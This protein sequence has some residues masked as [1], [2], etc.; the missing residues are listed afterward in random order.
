MKFGIFIHWG[1]FSVPSYGSEWFWHN[2]ACGDTKVKQFADRNFPKVKDD[3][4][5]YANL[6]KAELFDADQWFVSEWINGPTGYLMRA[7][8]S[9]S[10]Q[11]AYTVHTQT[12][13][14]MHRRDIYYCVCLIFFFRLRLVCLQM[15]PL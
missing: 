2:Y 8:L 3:Y 1:V 4:P 10:Q 6:W 5:Q 13:A 9:H 7:T 11:Q 12:A 15:F 14:V